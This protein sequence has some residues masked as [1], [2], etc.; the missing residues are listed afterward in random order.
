MCRD[1]V[2]GHLVAE[3]AQRRRGTLWPS[4]CHIATRGIVAL[5]L[6]EAVDRVAGIEEDAVELHGESL[7]MV[8]MKRV[9]TGGW[10]LSWALES[11]SSPKCEASMAGGTDSSRV[12]GWIQT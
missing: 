3:P 2:I 9:A 12:E 8:L 6:A 5:F 1:I 7:G 4:R 10:S 11:L